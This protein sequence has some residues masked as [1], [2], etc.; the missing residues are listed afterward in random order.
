MAKVQ[1]ENDLRTFVDEVSALR[2]ATP[3][4]DPEYANIEKSYREASDLLE[5]S[6]GVAIDDADSDYQD[7][8]AR[9][10]EAMKAIDEAKRKIEKISKVIAITAQ[11]IDI[12]GKVMSKI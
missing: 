4:S 5:R 2:T 3:I 9:I 1:I 7:F 6:I 10:R 11:V 8:T 12:A